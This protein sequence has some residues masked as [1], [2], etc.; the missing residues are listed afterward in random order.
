[1]QRADS[2]EKTLMLGKIEGRRRRGWQRMR[3]LDGITNSI[4]MSLVE[5]REL[6]MD[7]R[8]WRAAVHGVSKSQ[9][10]LSHWTELIGLLFAFLRNVHTVSPSG[11]TSSRSHTRGPLSVWTAVTPSLAPGS[12]Q[13][14]L[15]MAAVLPTAFFSDRGRWVCLQS[16]SLGALI[17]P[18]VWLLLVVPA[19]LSCS[20]PPLYASAFQVWVGWGRGGTFTQCPE[21]L[22]KL[23]AH[24]LFPARGTF[25]VNSLGVPC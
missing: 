8:A 17:P 25:S 9:T 7:S 13:W 20:E 3:W 22:R 11:C 2:F 4:D 18:A 19:R 15:A 16:R 1:M 14:V 12:R 24:L 6:V 5:L 10:R 21:R 23:V